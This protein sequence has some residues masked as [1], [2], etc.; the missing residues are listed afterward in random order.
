MADLVRRNYQIQGKDRIKA[1]RVFKRQI[2]KWGLSMPS[3]EPQV[4]DLGTGEFYKQGLI[5]YWI[6]NEDKEGYCGKFLFVFNGQ[7]CPYHL[8]KFKHETFFV[9]KGK[10][11]MKVNGKTKIRKQG[12]TVTMKQGALHS[13]TGKGPALL[14]EVSKPCKPGDNH[15]H[16]KS[17]GVNG[18]L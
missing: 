5:E 11:S 13:F 17:I 3:V 15:M 10:V 16:D 8:H 4:L 6:C 12:E 7:T 9:L 2:Q 18:Q 1:L 14:L